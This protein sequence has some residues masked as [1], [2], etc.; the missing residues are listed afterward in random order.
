MSRTAQLPVSDLS[1]DLHNFR[2]VPQNG[3]F[4]AIQA[5]ISISPDFFGV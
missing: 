5:M 4:E 2:T 1:I 3:E